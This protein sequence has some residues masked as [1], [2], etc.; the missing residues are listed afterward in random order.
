MTGF[1][2]LSMEGREI[3]RKELA[4]IAQESEN[5]FMGVNCGIMDQFTVAMGAQHH[6]LL[7][8][9]S[10]LEYEKVPFRASGYKIVIGNTNK[11]RGLVDSAYNERRSQCEQ[12]VRELKKAFPKLEFLAELTVGDWEK[13]EHLVADPVIRKRARHVITENG[14]VLQS[15]EA[16]KKDDLQTFGRLMSASH[17]SLRDDYEVSCREL[18]V[19]V[20]AAMNIE[21]CSAPA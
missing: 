4:L 12:A 10:T 18:D 6:A 3:D 2:F 5:E 11:R 19:M 20:E 16:L 14:R 7:L 1:G 21:G 9:C 8:K 15:V 13:H 17:A